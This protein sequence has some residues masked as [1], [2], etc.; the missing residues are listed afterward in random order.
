MI[1]KVIRNNFEMVKALAKRWM[2]LKAKCQ[3]H[4]SQNDLKSFYS[5]SVWL[6]ICSSLMFLSNGIELTLW[7]FTWKISIFID[8]GFFNINSDEG[9][10]V[11]CAHVKVQQVYF[12]CSLLYIFGVFFVC[13]YFGLSYQISNHS[14]VHLHANNLC[15]FFRIKLLALF[16]LWMMIKTMTMTMVVIIRNEQSSLYWKQIVPSFIQANRNLLAS[17]RLQSYSMFV[18][19]IIICRT[20][21]ELKVISWKRDE[22]AW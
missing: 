3:V 14:F 13:V 10:Y 17:M 9:M 1:I 18:T 20:E 12:R 8:F 6:S 16:P 7:F 15:F 5:Y 21:Y 11:Y 19:I 2:A 22:M 4:W